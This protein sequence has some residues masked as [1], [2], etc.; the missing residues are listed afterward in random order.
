MTAPYGIEDVGAFA[1]RGALDDEPDADAVG[2]AGEFCEDA[3]GAGE[4]GGFAAA[5]AKWRS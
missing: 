1:G 2:L 3:R 4:I 5:L